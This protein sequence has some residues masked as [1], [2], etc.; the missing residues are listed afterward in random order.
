MYKQNNGVYMS[1]KV[2]M[3]VNIQITLFWDVMLF[4]WLESYQ[5]F[6]ETYFPTLWV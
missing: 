3:M 2:L 5:S 6:G 1:I 4:S